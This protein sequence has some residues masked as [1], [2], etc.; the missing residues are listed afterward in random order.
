MLHE[1]DDDSLLSIV[2]TNVEDAILAQNE[3]GEILISWCLIVDQ[4]S[5]LEKAIRVYL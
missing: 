2:E 5:P 1:F 4:R 3:P